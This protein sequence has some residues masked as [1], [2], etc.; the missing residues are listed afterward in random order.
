MKSRKYPKEKIVLVRPLRFRI[1]KSIGRCWYL[2]SQLREFLDKSR[3]DCNY[4][5]FPRRTLRSFNIARRRRGW[6]LQS[7]IQRQNQFKN[8]IKL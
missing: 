8:L 3:E 4:K 7:P 2:G 5:F 1:E 6:S